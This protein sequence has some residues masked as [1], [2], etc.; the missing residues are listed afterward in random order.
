MENNKEIHKLLE[1]YSILNDMGRVN[2]DA[3]REKIYNLTFRKKTILLNKLIKISA[4]ILFPL[5]CSTA[6]YYYVNSR[7][8]ELVNNALITITS[9]QSGVMEY[10]LPDSS[11]VWLSGG[12]SISYKASIENNSVREV[13]LLG[14][15]Y[16]NVKHI[17]TKPFIVKIGEVNVSVT[18][19]QFNCIEKGNNIEITLIEGG[20]N[21]ENNLGEIVAKLEANQQYVYNNS[22]R[23]G[24]LIKNVNS[25]QFMAWKDGELYFKDSNLSFVVERLQKAYNINVV[26]EDKRL[27]EKKITASFK[28]ERIEDIIEIIS[29]IIGVEYTINNIDN[30]KTVTFN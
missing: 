10:L 13:N 18:G 14:E 17:K 22:T 9:P 15:G 20:V 27:L 11:S 19:T 29:I 16:F 3:A 21:I 8:V 23:S 7:K 1:A 24:E 30:I 2:K 28:N 26:I 4:V 12:S 6:T 5:I 25:H